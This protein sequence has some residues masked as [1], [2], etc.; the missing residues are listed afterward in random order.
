MHIVKI[1]ILF[2]KKTCCNLLVIS[3]C[4]HTDITKAA[5]SSQLH[6][7]SSVF[8]A[9]SILACLTLSNIFQMDKFS[10]AAAHMC[11]KFTVF[12]AC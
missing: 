9:F 4:Y 5:M 2:K 11:N 1:F 12:V 10:V 7:C 3:S 8:L 6:A